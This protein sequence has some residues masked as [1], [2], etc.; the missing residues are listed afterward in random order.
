[1]TT[2]TV[3]DTQ[4]TATETTADTTATTIETKAADTTKA[5][6][7]KAVETKTETAADTKATDKTTAPPDKAEWRSRAIAEVFGDEK[8]TDPPESKAEREKLA[9]LAGRY[10][11]MGDA[12]KALREAQR[13]ISSGEVKPPLPKDA[14]PEQIAEWRKE[15]GIPEAPDK[16]DLGL[17]EGTVLGDADKQVFDVLLGKMHGANASPDVVKATAAAY[18]ELRETQTQEIH[19]RNEEAK[20]NVAAELGA[21]WGSDYRANVDGIK[22]LLGQA[23]SSVA[24]AITSARGS[25]GIA[26]LNKP[27][28]VRWLAAHARELGYVGATVVPQGGDLGKGIDDELDALKAEMSKDIDAWHKNQKGQ[29]RFIQL[30]EAKQRRAAK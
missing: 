12:L 14:K 18:L 16:Y 5:T 3:I 13:K 17:P 9:K 25:D 24:E 6:E 21:E 8:D 30:M 4:A 2:E 28:V 11:T 7:T 22:S 23:D 15:N 20:G 27:E 19:N 1:M 29:A 10:N 26:L